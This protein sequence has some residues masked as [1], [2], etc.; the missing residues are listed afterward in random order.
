MT[1]FGIMHNPD[2]MVDGAALQL[3]KPKT[4][5]QKLLDS[6]GLRNFELNN[7]RIRKDVWVTEDDEKKLLGYCEQMGIMVMDKP[8]EKTRF[9][10]W[11][12]EDNKRYDKKDKETTTIK[13][14]EAKIKILELEKELAELKA[15]KSKKVLS[16]KKKIWAKKK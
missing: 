6:Y 5:L 15:G 8:Y 14:L 7:K 11:S 4:P 2:C 1:N 3:I 9:S 16:P 13:E 12:I 10:S